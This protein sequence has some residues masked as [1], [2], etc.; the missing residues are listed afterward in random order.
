MNKMQ[1]RSNKKDEKLSILG[2]GCMRFTKK[3]G[4]IDQD[5]AEK[6]M[7]RAL[8]LGVNYF[9][10]AYIYPGSEVCLGRFIKKYNCRDRINIATKL[11][12]YSIKKNEDL[13]R[14]FNEELRRLGTD[15]V[16]YYLMHMLNDV[17]SWKRLL[18]LGIREWIEDKQKSGAI[19]NLG[20]SFHGG[21]E[22]FKKLLDAYDW[23]FCQIQFN[24]MDEHSQ[25][26]L[27]GLKYAAAKNIPVVVM[28]P[29]R[30]GSL[31]N[32]P[33]EAMREINKF[34]VKRSAAEW[35]LKWIWNHPEVTVVLSGMNDIGQV[36]EN[37]RIAS[38]SRPNSLDEKELR[39]YERILKGINKGLKIRCTGCGYCQPC[40]H[41]VDIPNCFAAFN[42]SFAQGYATGIREYFMCTILRRSKSNAGLCVSCGACEKKCPQHIRIRKGLSAVRRRFENPLFKVGAAIAGRIMKY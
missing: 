34:P 30:G 19:R 25:A 28:E 11:P 42:H 23:D 16:D 5:K 2:Y 20:F 41:G 6:E 26:G 15:H 4:A 38:E 22:S 27:E 35:G 10:T 40:P 17:S 1:Y 14:Y 37:C 9:D 21:T 8:D 13:D 32:L 36:E 29:L 7:K 18:S 39:L 33:G 31:V 12:H 24:Y 3:A